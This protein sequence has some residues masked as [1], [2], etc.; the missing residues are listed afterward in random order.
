MI[1]APLN[2]TYFRNGKRAYR[3]KLPR[4]ANPY[5]FLMEKGHLWDDGWLSARLGRLTRKK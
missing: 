5:N 2:I 3:D 4:T 1:L